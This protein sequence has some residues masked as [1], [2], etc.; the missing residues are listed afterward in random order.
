VA[1]PL[2]AE[3]VDRHSS[4]RE[5][6]LAR[7]RGTL[8]AT[9][10]ITFGDA[11]QAAEAAASVA[12]VHRT[13][14]GG[15]STPVGRVPAGTA[16]AADDPELAMWVHATL[17]WSALETY[18]RFVGPIPEA[19]RA[20]YYEESKRF[21]RLFGVTD[22]VMPATYA[23]FAGYWR[24]AVVGLAVGS[25]AAR[26]ADQI[27]RPPFRFPL[28]ATLPAMRAVTASLLPEPVRTG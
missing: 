7:L 3:A 16:Y 5:D 8:D 25:A 21:A 24:R 22:N 13:V 14:R 10:R 18:A 27:L 26:L 12:A 9:L 17:V 15:M 2:V 4:F 23:G 28:R 11:R 20:R 1:N 19:G 6:P